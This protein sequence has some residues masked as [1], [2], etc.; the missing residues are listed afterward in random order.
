MCKTNECFI[1]IDEPPAHVRINS[2]RSGFTDLKPKYV[3]MKNKDEFSRRPELQLP[4]RC[5][6]FKIQAELEG[7]FLDIL[8][9][10][11]L[12][13]RYCVWV[14]T[15]LNSKWYRLS[16]PRLHLTDTSGSQEESYF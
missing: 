10:M 8:S 5:G 1:F 14:R 7:V 16:T 4:F 6:D 2:F 3:I 13:D 12:K 9:N 11:T 15:L